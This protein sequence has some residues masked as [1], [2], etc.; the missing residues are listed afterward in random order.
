MVYGERGIDLRED[1]CETGS[2]IGPARYNLVPISL[3]EGVLENVETQPKIGSEVGAPMTPVRR[4][5]VHKTPSTSIIRAMIKVTSLRRWVSQIC[6]EASDLTPLGVD[7][8]DH[9]ET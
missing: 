3:E 1:G 6:V 9:C 8:L 5:S 4:P 2:E 7:T